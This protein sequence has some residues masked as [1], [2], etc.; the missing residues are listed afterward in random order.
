MIA[1]L[2]ALANA[3]LTSA[4]IA[5]ANFAGVDL[6]RAHLAPLNAM[7]AALDAID[8]SWPARP[9]PYDREGE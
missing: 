2:D 5:R 4:N 8:W 3:N 6:T 9:K 1:R 7:H